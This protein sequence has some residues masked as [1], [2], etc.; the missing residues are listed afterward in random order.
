MNAVNDD[1]SWQANTKKEKA[2]ITKMKVTMLKARQ[3]HG[4]KY[5]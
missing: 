2:R 1:K 5:E 3:K 4:M